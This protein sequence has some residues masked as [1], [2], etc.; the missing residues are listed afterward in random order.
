MAI[1]KH[2]IDLVLDQAWF[3]IV[4]KQNNQ[5]L[6]WTKCERENEFKSIFTPVYW[7]EKI[8]LNSFSLPFIGERK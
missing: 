5:I 4:Y 1:I 6:R 8:N 7:E 2:M 3:S